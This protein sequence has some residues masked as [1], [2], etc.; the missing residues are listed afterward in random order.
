M[1]I[2][3]VEDN[4]DGKDDKKDGNFVRELFQLRNLKE[5]FASLMK[6]RDNHRRTFLILLV[7][8][9]MLCFQSMYLDN[10]SSKTNSMDKNNICYLLGF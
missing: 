6:K 10:I 7:L 2:I 8:V 1:G 5:G 3:L 9:K 4:V